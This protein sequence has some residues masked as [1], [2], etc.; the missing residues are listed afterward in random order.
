MAD[1][2]NI[3]EAASLGLH[4]MTYLASQNG[5]H[6]TTASIAT[7]LDVSEHHLAKVMQRLA[8]AELVESVRGPHGGFRLAK[9]ATQI[10]L[11]DVFEAVEGKA[12]PR[13]CL[14]SI[15]PRCPEEKCILGGLNIRIFKEVR[16]HFQKTKLADVATVFGEH[17]H[18]NNKADHPHR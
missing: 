14:L 12:E 9:D 6:R 11:L 18:E 7:V 8:K 3:S 1:F 17:H 13:R 2:V 15:E 5:G 4:A 10:T 16:E